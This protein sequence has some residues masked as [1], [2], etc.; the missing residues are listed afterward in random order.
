MDVRIQ[1]NEN[2]YEGTKVIVC[3]WPGKGCKVGRGECGR[4]IAGITRSQKAQTM[5]LSAD[6]AWL[7]LPPGHS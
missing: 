2:R 3:Q 1:N 6:A 7:V 4:A 5:M